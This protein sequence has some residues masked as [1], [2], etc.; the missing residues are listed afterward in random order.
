MRHPAYNLRPNKAVDRSLLVER[1]HELEEAQLINTKDCVYYGFGGPFLDDFRILA[2]HFPWMSFHSLEKKAHTYKRQKFH[3]FSPRINLHHH[4]VEQ[5]LA[6][7][8]MKS[9]AHLIWWLDY[10][11]LGENELKDITSLANSLSPGDFLRVTANA[12]VMFDIEQLPEAFRQTAFK[13]AVREEFDR[14]KSKYEGYL[15]DGLTPP[16]VFD[17]QIYP[18]LCVSMIEKAL[19]NRS[20]SAS[21]RIWHISSRVYRDGVQMVT[22]EFYISPRIYSGDNKG[23]K[24]LN[25]CLKNAPTPELINVPNLSIKERLHLEGITPKHIGNINRL[26]KKLGYN[27]DNSQNLHQQA[28]EQYARF[29]KHYPMLGKIAQ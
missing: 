24:Y 11:N 5:F 10:T 23:L 6:N 9:A 15:P 7:E 19:G 14:F 13:D 22:C 8:D 20:N 17:D 3:K 12:D 1:I 4:S 25:N 16:E 28:I 27:I 26:G 2:D 21:T 29:H 18:T